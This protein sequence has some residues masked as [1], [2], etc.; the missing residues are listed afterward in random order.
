MKKGVAPKGHASGTA[1]LADQ[2]TDSR[3][4]MIW[5]FMLF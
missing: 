1:G 2:S 3:R 4:S 5:V